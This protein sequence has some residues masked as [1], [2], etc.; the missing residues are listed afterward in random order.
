MKHETI[1]KFKHLLY[2]FNIINVMTL[3]DHLSW[4]NK[5]ESKPE[6]GFN[7]GTYYSSA[8]NHPDKSGHDCKTVC[9][10]AGHAFLLSQTEK[11]ERWVESENNFT[12][13]R[14][15]LGLSNIELSYLYSGKFGKKGITKITLDDTIAELDFMIETGR[16]SMFESIIEEIQ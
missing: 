4:L 7:M 10:L 1:P 12:N 14:Q 9:C 15:W 2:C 16:T 6:V 13:V 5:K 3:R 11:L 8:G